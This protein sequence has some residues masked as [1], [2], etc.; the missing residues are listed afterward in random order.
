M[1]SMNISFL[2]K[3][4]HYFPMLKV[5]NEKRILKENVDLNNFY[6]NINHYTKLYEELEPVDIE[7]GTIP[8]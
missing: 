6:A 8:V 5:G 1:E 2:R 7:P 3:G 4:D